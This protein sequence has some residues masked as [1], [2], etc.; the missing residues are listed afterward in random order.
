MFRHVVMFRWSTEASADQ[1]DRV[2]AAL[3]ELP[4]AIPTLRSY[5]FGPDAAVNEGNFDY[6]VVADFDDVAGYLTYRDHPAHQAVV[7]EHI[8]PI[9][10]ERTAVQYRLED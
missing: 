7:T 1:K 5:R 8:A 4:S 2:A 6:V 9:V 3:G 10:A